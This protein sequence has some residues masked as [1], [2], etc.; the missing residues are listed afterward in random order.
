MSGRDKS[1]PMSW[2]GKVEQYRV[3]GYIGGMQCGEDQE[4][5]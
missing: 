3:K 5:M 4:I 1:P 2:G